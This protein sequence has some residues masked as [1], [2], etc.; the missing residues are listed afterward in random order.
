M[1]RRGLASQLCF[2]CERAARHS[3]GKENII[4]EVERSNA[5]AIG[6]YKSLKYIPEVKTTDSG[7]DSKETEWITFTKSLNQI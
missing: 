3:W 4:L 6:L 1:K 7:A 2:I 5:A